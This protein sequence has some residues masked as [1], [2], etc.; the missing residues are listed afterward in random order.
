MMGQVCIGR[1]NGSEYVI[2]NYLIETNKRIE[3]ENKKR[4]KQIKT[5]KRVKKLFHFSII[6]YSLPQPPLFRSHKSENP[7]VCPS[8]IKI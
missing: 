8:A 6:N 7:Q 4:S 1:M 2:R 3:E 5:D